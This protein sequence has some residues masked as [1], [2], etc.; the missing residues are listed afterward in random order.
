M[1][2]W[3]AALG[4]RRKS[5]ETLCRHAGKFTLVHFKKYSANIETVISILVTGSASMYFSTP[6][7]WRAVSYM[8]KHMHVNTTYQDW[9]SL[10][11]YCFA[12]L[13]TI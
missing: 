2:L 4:G 11:C 13:T 6:E 5:V 8:P 3:D 10:R 1:Y 7:V 12:I 9:Y